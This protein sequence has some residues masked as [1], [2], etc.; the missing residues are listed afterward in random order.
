MKRRDYLK[1]A[2][3]STAAIT[4]ITTLTGIS[5]A[6][7]PLNPDFIKADTIG[8]YDD[9]SFNSY[10]LRLYTTSDDGNSVSVSTASDVYEDIKT[11]LGYAVNR[12]SNL[13]GVRIKLYDTTADFTGLTDNQAIFNHCDD[14][15]W[16]SKFENAGGNNVWV[17]TRDGVAYPATFSPTVYKPDYSNATKSTTEA[18]FP[19]SMADTDLH[20][21]IHWD[22]NH[23][24]FHNM[25]NNDQTSDEDGCAG[26][27]HALA[28]AHY[29]STYLYSTWGARPYSDALECGECSTDKS[30]VDYH[31]LHPSSCEIT[32]VENTISWAKSNNR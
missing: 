25:V 19:H 17:W 30:S 4:G 9:N 28:S 18:D 5:R 22:A 8:T 32:A 14:L 1:H 13:D 6:E 12:A 31:G 24:N 21:G 26:N 20:D 27:D 10:K 15:I 23:E 29:E 16:G 2:S 11:A 3:T 7:V